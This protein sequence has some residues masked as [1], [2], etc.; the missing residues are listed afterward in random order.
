MCKVNE[1][2][3]VEELVCY[4]KVK[5][6]RVYRLVYERRIP[7]LKVGRS[8]RFRKTDIDSWMSETSNGRS[9]DFFPNRNGQRLPFTKRAC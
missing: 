8:L 6:E 3:T 4:L 7:F 1:L 9:E 2:L 5:R